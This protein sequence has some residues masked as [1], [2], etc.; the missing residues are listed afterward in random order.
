MLELFA[1]EELLSNT[2]IEEELIAQ[3]RNFAQEIEY[4]NR[5]E[6]CLRRAKEVYE[7]INS[8]YIRMFGY[9]SDV[10]KELESRLENG[11]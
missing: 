5:D 6:T 1:R 4:I 8:A 3:A 9:Q 7:K 10:L 2:E 11:L